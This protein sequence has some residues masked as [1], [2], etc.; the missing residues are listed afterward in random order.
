ML[1]L[2]AVSNIFNVNSNNVGGEDIVVKA[3]S[4]KGHREEEDGGAHA[5]RKCF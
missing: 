3:V 2:H 4:A 5:V 1:S